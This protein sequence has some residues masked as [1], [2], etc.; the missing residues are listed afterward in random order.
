[1]NFQESRSLSGGA[2]SF[3]STLRRFL[4]KRGVQLISDPGERFD[5][6]LLNALTG[7][8]T[9]ERL[10]RI[11]AL[12]RP[13]IHRKVGYRVSG[14]TQ[15]RTIQN[16]VVWGDKL[17]I[18]MS[19]YIDHSIFQSE[20]SR[21]NFVAQGFIGESSVIV[22][23]VDETI[24]NPHTTRIFNCWKPNFR[25][26]WDHNTVFRLAIVTWSTDAAKGFDEYQKFDAALDNT[27]RVEIWFI[28][29]MPSELSF[30]NIRCFP[31]RSHAGLARLLQ[32][33]HGF[34]QMAT[35]ETCSNALLEAISCGLPAIYKDSGSSKELAREFGVE[36]LGDP[37]AA[38]AELQRKYDLLLRKTL[39]NTYSIQ[40]AGNN[41]FNLIKE[42]LRRFG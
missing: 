23:G 24:F 28:G 18:D 26:F 4:R 25:K 15:M 40:Y 39:T 19:P 29:R 12:G 41:Y 35:F 42:L 5:I 36:Y 3:L 11:R 7:D 34:I 27:S 10:K 31:A 21:E 22:N 37:I 13:V 16:G 6:A 14:S 17:Q 30:R 9:L 1:M 8:L 38:I 20:Y 32:Q 2:N 33:C